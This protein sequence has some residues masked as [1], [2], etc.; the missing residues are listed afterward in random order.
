[1]YRVA[2]LIK[3]RGVTKALQVIGVILVIVLS[4]LFVVAVA[5]RIDARQHECWVLPD[6]WHYVV[7]SPSN[8]S[9][10]ARNNAICQYG[11]QAVYQYCVLIQRPVPCPMT[12]DNG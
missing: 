10:L 9:L 12:E 1:M 8:G 7:P 2:W 11:E 4:V 6:G 3:H 5:M